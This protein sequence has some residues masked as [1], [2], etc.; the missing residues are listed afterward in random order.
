MPTKSLLVLGG[1]RSGKSRFAQRLAETS[2]ARPA[3]IATAEAAGALAYAARAAAR[4]ACWLFSDGFRNLGVARYKF[5]KIREITM[6]AVANVPSRQAPDGG[7]LDIFSCAACPDDNISSE[8]VSKLGV[9]RRP[10]SQVGRR[11]AESDVVT[12]ECSVHNG[13]A[14]LEHELRSSRRPAHLLFCGHSAMQQP[15]DRTFG[16]R[17]LDGS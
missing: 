10:T 14:N 4:S 7:S 17:L 5:S 15:M 1:A 16:S 12:F 8:T 6:T 13:S 3:P 9:L 2:G 11:L